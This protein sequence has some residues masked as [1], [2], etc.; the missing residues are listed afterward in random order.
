[1]EASLKIGAEVSKE[2]S[3]NLGDLIDRVFS[4]AAKNR[5]DQD[6]IRHAL[7]VVG[8][9]LKVEGTTVTNCTFE[10]DKTVNT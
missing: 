4:S 8:T 1:M 5:M 2:T 3:K 7:S 6:T 10:G 9:G